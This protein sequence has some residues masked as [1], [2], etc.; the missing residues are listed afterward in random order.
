MGIWYDEKAYQLLKKCSEAKDLTEWNE[1][2]K[3]T[4]YAPI[5]LRF[6][7]LSN[8]Y[9]QK[10]ELQNVDLRGSSFGNADFRFADVRDMNISSLV[11]VIAY[12]ICFSIG[13]IIAWIGSQL[14]DVWL[15]LITIAGA[16]GFTTGS[17]IIASI[18]VTF[19]RNDFVSAINIIMTISAA[20]TIFEIGLV[21][22]IINYIG[23]SKVINYITLILNN[24][25]DFVSIS[26][27]ILNGLSITVA[28]VGFIIEFV[29]VEVYGKPISFA[30]N[31]KEVIGFRS[32]Y[33]QSK[34]INIA[35]ELQQEASE[36]S[37][38]IESTQDDE[39]KQKLHNRLEKL[40]EKIDIY[41][42]QEEQARVQTTQIEKVISELQ[43][44][45]FYIDNTILKIKWHNRFYYS[46][47]FSLIAIFTYAI[48]HGYID[49]KMAS[50]AVLFTK[51]LPTFGTIF[52]VI[53]FYGSPVLLGISLII[54]FI[55]QINK[56]IDKIT[57]LQE[58]ERNIKQIASTIK[59]KAQIGMSDE[60]FV[61]ETKSLIQ[62]YQEGM[63]TGMFTKEKTSDKEDKS[64]SS[65]Y[66]EKMIANG[67]SKLLMQALKK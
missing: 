46:A 39:T 51:T 49:Q 59:A 10:A 66:R 56:N 37:K 50:F 58:Q 31:P 38:T 4:N 36:L 7:D 3:A 61:K 62:K 1:Y 17:I 21:F 60:E 18:I 29:G 11:A 23:I 28:L 41:K 8:F 32:K 6:A 54:Y 45:Y 12:T 48:A 65:T 53:L 34:P 9:L 26:I 25:H 47:I 42:L 33:F 24:F 57:E 44:P 43:A 13:V 15:S 2:R 30:K 16:I 55:T 64:S 67:M 63:M 20:I 19:R 40:E 52:G 27:L 35:E 14:G 22:E 5:N